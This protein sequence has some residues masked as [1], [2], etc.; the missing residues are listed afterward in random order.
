MKRCT[1]KFLFVIVLVLAIVLGSFTICPAIETTVDKILADKNSYD[2]K[3][4]SV[5]G[6]VSAN[7]KFKTIK[8]GKDYTTFSLL[9]DSG[10]RIN[11]F[12]WGKLKLQGGQKVRVTGIYHKVMKVGQSTFRNEIEAMEIT[13]P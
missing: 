6:T 5:S 1:S 7:L 12:I 4:V 11:V 8:G 3:E 9:G 13:A 2:G 10:R